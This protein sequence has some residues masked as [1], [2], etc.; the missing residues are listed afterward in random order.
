MYNKRRHGKVSSIKGRRKALEARIVRNIRNDEGQKIDLVKTKAQ[1]RQGS[2]VKADCFE[3]RYWVLDEDSGLVDLHVVPLWPH[4]L[5]NLVQVVLEDS[6]FK[7]TALDVKMLLER[8]KEGDD[9]ESATAGNAKK[10]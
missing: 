5:I 3:L 9:D 7:G 2:L 8:I 10:S 4:E 6:T 1:V